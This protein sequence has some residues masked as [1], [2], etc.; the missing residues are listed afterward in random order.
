M[1]RI[2]NLNNNPFSRMSTEEEL[3][4]IDSI[5]YKPRYYDELI[6]LL[7]T[8]VS[9]FIIGRRGQG[10]SM[11]IHN[12]FNDLTKSNIL[13]VLIT[14]YDEIPLS[15]NENHFLYVIM[16]SLTI[17]ISKHLLENPKDLAKLSKEQKNKVSFFIELFYKDYCS[18]QFIESAKVI[19][20]IKS[21]NLIKRFIN[22]HLLGL[23]NSTINGVIMMTS[24]LIRDSISLP[25]PETTSNYQE[26]I[27]EFSQKKINSFTIDEVSSWE[28]TDLIN[29][30]SALIRISESLEYKSIVVL[31][32]KVDEFQSINGDVEK[33]TDFSIEILTDTDL[34]LS[35]NI[36][37]VFSLWSEIKKSLNKRG[38]RFDKFKE[39]DTIW[40]KPDL[41]KIIDKRLLH[42][43]INK[44]NPVTF[45]SL[46]PYE[47]D[48]L[49][50]I[51]LAN[52][53]PR[54]L[55]RLLGEIYNENPEAKGLVTFTST[56]ISD[57]IRQFCLNFDYISQRPTKFGNRNDLDSWINRL[58]RM[59]VL[60]FTIEHLNETFLQK[61][62]T[63]YKH[64]ETLMKLGLVE[65]N[66][67]RSPNNLV[68][69]DVIDPR[70]KH[71]IKI[72]ILNINER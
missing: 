15:K 19:K 47:N 52:N 56:S 31:F 62:P 65:E 17:E 68:Q 26:Y 16:Q 13:S 49:T 50:I 55:I 42:F 18:S 29:M 46:I 23:I 53:S 51:E 25:D 61:N 11:L 66:L 3:D 72:G 69:Y 12:L 57:G 36:S 10:K 38:V 4:F 8:G 39:V 30:L 71:L 9:R 32:D 37:I 63:S 45:E 28:R 54:S 34:L 7:S 1:N 59:R 58:L 33:I 21:S 64:I 70:I 44:A 6:E 27:K 24:K 22:R 14:R 5:F 35:K 41:P 67:V 2:T 43:S 48:R 60:T 40:R 20:K